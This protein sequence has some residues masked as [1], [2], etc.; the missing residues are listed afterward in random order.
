M[1][2]KRFDASMKRKTEYHKPKDAISLGK[3]KWYIWYETTDYISL[4]L[5]WN[6]R[7]REV[8]LNFGVDYNSK[9][10]TDYSGYYRLDGLHQ[11]AMSLRLARPKRDHTGFSRWEPVARD[12]WK[13][14]TKLE[15]Y[16]ANEAR[17]LQLS[18]AIIGRVMLKEFPAECKIHRH[19]YSVDIYTSKPKPNMSTEEMLKILLDFLLRKEDNLKTLY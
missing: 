13:H 14:P 10:R 3:C 1:K 7:Y 12:R 18:H 15:E 8:T 16:Y 9:W 4:E 2:N 11:K 17:R 19:T 6:G 5:M